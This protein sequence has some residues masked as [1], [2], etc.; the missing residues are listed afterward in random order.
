MGHAAYM[1][2][3]RAIAA[4]FCRDRGCSGCIWCRPEGPTPTPRPPGWG[5][6]A[7]ARAEEHANR[8]VTAAARHG[9]ARPT[10]EALALAV[11]DAARVGAATAM[12]AAL[13][14]LADLP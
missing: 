7:R 13:S 11:Q 1:R 12:G 3:S 8:M 14:A 6:K 5:G 4:Q 10:P 9:L 2:G